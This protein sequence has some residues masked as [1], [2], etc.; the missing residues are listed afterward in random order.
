MFRKDVC[1][2]ILTTFMFYGNTHSLKFLVNKCVS[3]LKLVAEQNRTEKNFYFSDIHV[4][5][6]PQQ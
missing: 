6:R 4:H 5:L 3:V 1:Q 2:N